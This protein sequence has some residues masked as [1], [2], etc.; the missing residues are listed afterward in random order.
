M[1]AS[2]YAE[3]TEKENCNLWAL[4]VHLKLWSENQ[5]ALTAARKEI[6]VS[7]SC[8]SHLNKKQTQDLIVQPTES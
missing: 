8:S 6:L 2:N 5:R 7:R 3:K 1:V 4:H